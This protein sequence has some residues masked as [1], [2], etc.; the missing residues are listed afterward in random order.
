[1]LLSFVSFSKLV[2]LVY[3]GQPVEN[4]TAYARY[5][6]DIC[7]YQQSRLQP[8]TIEAIMLQM[9]TDQF[10][11]REEYKNM[12]D[13][14]EAKDIELILDNYQQE[15][16]LASVM[17]ISDVE[18]LDNLENDPEDGSILASLVEKEHSLP[19]T[20]KVTRTHRQVG[21]TQGPRSLQ[22]HNR[23]PGQYKE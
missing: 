4:N 6:R 1:V 9:C 3:T 10:V 15:D 14:M 5:T 21:S 18:D 16:D 8:D 2:I 20:S 19:S 23:H 17:Y 11:I 7:H 13:E 12:L 22:Y